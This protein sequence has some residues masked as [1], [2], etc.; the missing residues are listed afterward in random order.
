MQTINTLI[1]FILI[2]FFFCIEGAYCL[3]FWEKSYNISFGELL[4]QIIIEKWYAQ[5]LKLR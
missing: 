2:S 4:L 1:Y 3:V 5:V